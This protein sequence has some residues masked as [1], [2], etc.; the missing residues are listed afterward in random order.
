M[1]P[2]AARAQEY[3]RRLSRRLEKP[4]R[5]ALRNAAMAARPAELRAV[6]SALA[7]GDV[8]GAVTA[9]WSDPPV[10]AAWETVRNV[11][12]HQTLVAANGSVR[13]INATLRFNLTTP[14]ASPTLIAAVRRWE[15]SAFTHI[16]GEVR[17]GLRS[18]VARE[19]DKG[20]GPLEAARAIKTRLRRGGLTEY[21]HGLVESF[22]QQLQE[23]PARAL[24]RTLRDK[25][26]DARL[27]SGKP[28]TAAEVD[29]RVAAYERKLSAWRAQTF[30]RTA[31]MQAANDGQDVAWRAMI[32]SGEVEYDEVR[33]YW[34]VG[35]DE[36]MC[37][38]CSAVPS[39][40]PSGVRLDEPFI[41]PNGLYMNPVLHPN[42]RCTTWT[43]IEYARTAPAITPGILRTRAPAA[44]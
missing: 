35:D 31:A 12:A 27:R 23:D 44:A 37:E 34:I 13:A 5:E 36:R 14:T 8:E 10:R 6:L 38:V 16:R 18:M 17:A 20:T 24:R 25:R 4:L 30:A 21:D 41:T 32:D 22:R 39:L 29:A 15:D 26:G 40:N 1:N 28:L 7:A 19:L 43:R 2:E 11:Y 9:M 42:C 33:R 3:L